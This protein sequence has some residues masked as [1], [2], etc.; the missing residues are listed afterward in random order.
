MLL[1]LVF[2]GIFQVAHYTEKPP[3]LE[4]VKTAFSTNVV[5]NSKIERLSDDRFYLNLVWHLRNDSDF[6]N[7]AAYEEVILESLQQLKEFF[8]IKA[9][10]D[11]REKALLCQDRYNIYRR[12]ISWLQ[13]FRTNKDTYFRLADIAGSFEHQPMIAGV[14]RSNVDMLNFTIEETR[15]MIIDIC[16]CRA[17]W[18]LK[19]TMSRADFDKFIA[20]INQRARYDG[21][22][23]KTK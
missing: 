7:R 5:Y 17:R 15:K 12:A 1:A 2:S 3:S 22:V 16:H 8:T 19:G 21:G 9:G 6:D 18:Y 14:Y 20:E 13:G 10:D 23:K 11:V 4:E